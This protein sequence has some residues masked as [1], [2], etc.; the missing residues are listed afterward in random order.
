LD[1]LGELE[2]KMGAL[3]SCLGDGSHSLEGVESVEDIGEYLREDD[4]LGEE[5]TTAFVVGAFLSIRF[6][7]FDVWEVVCG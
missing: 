2:H 4:H 6:I 7:I 3:R 1:W 5:E